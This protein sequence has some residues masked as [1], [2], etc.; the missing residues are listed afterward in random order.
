M[1]HLSQVV[2]KDV[3]V[4]MFILANVFVQKSVLKI[5]KP[6]NFLYMSILLL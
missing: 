1:T 4:P 6:N 5:E 2:Q 3:R